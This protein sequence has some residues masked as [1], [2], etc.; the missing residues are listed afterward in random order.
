MRCT[1]MRCTPMRYTPMRHAHE[2]HACEMHAHEV[3]AHELSISSVNPNILT[4]R[5]ADKELIRPSCPPHRAL[6][7]YS[8]HLPHNHRRRRDL[9][10]E[11]RSPGNAHLLKSTLYAG[12]FFF[13]IL[14][15]L[16]NARPFLSLTDSLPFPSPVY[17]KYLVPCRHIFYWKPAWGAFYANIIGIS[18]YLCLNRAL[19]ATRST[20]PSLLSGL[21]KISI[22]VLGLRPRGSSR[23]VRS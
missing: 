22:R 5:P 1:P 18:G 17:R 4:H 10:A 19:A 11:P 2:M 14:Q 8:S 3:H 23:C 6:H 7:A 16:R 12:S 13:F 15:S 9:I 20:N 21:R